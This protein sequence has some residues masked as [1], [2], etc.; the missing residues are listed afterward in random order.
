MASKKEMEKI[1]ISVKKKFEDNIKH[2][3]ELA[4]NQ[5]QLSNR[6]SNLRL[7][8]SLAAIAGVITLFVRGYKELGIGILVAAIILFSF[9][10][11]KHHRAQ[12]TL[13]KTICKIN[14]NQRYVDRINGDWT[15]FKED[16]NLLADA[17]HPYTNDLNI[18]GPKSLFQWMNLGKTYYGRK[19]LQDL[20]SDPKKEIG[21][22]KKRQ[23]A[24]RELAESFDFCQQLECEGM[25][26][27]GVGED[28]QKFLLHLESADRFFKDNWIRSIFYLLPFFTVLSAILFL[29][30]FPIPPQIPLS[31]II[32]QLLITIGG[33]KRVSAVLNIGGFKSLPD[34][35]VPLKVFNKTKQPPS[36]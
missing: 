29:L 3:N 8:F 27:G 28:P 1:A 2:F 5:E 25:L 32:I 19:M 9:L 33:S 6:I 13:K 7:F 15:K 10:V 11:I 16:G 26:A 14:I 24:V 23:N 21:L 20:L 36:Y 35:L 22:I 31:L 17:N 12:A 34:A 4:K 30:K 18:F